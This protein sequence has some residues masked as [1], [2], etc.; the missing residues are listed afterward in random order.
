MV[1]ETQL[2]AQKAAPSRPSRSSSAALSS[3]ASGGAAKRC[4]FHDAERAW[5]GRVRELQRRAAA[6]PHPTEPVASSRKRL[7]GGTQLGIPTANIPL[8][9]LTIGGEDTLDSGIYYG[10]AGLECDPLSPPNSEV[11]T[12]ARRVSLSEKVRSAGARLVNGVGSL[13]QGS[14][15]ESASGSEAEDKSGQEAQRTG[16]VYAMVMSVGWNPFYKN[17]VR[18]VVCLLCTCLLAS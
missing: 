15:E 18:S 11:L 14:D 16:R 10:W 8:T 4:V 13:M 6:P 3:R 12:P 5:G 1:R 9:G 7:T 2:S 17:T